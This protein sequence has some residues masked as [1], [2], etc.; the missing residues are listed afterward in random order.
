[1]GSVDVPL[2]GQCTANTQSGSWLSHTAGGK[3]PDG[4]S[5]KEGICTWRPVSLV[6][7]IDLECLSKQAGMR[8]ACIADIIAAGG[9]IPVPFQ[10]WIY[11]RS[12]PIFLGAFASDD[13]SQGGCPSL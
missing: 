1:M 8:K 10:D 3:C 9:K 5:V 2:S 12:L 6:K 13:P 11:N 4:Q 7:T